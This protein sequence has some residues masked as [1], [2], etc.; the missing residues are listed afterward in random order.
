MSSKFPNLF[1]GVW[2]EWIDPQ[3]VMDFKIPFIHNE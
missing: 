1:N 2:L 3:H